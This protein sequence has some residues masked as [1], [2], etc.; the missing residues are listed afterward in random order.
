MKNQVILKKTAQYLASK[1]RLS[2]T[3]LT[4]VTNNGIIKLNNNNDI[5]PSPNQMITNLTPN[6]FNP[7]KSIWQKGTLVS[8]FLKKFDTSTLMPFDTFLMIEI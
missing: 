5:L 2:Q 7:K 4:T 3:N 8:K 1:K 6:Y